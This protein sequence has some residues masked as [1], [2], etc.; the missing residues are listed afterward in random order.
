[1][2]V[3]KDAKKLLDREKR[4]AAYCSFCDEKIMLIEELTA[5]SINRMTKMKVDNDEF[6]KGQ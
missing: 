6:Y 5:T 4:G 1:M 2:L 3:E